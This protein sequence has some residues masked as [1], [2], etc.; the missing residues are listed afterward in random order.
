MARCPHSTTRRSSSVL[1]GLV[2]ADRRVR[3]S[4]IWLVSRVEKSRSG[5]V[6]AVVAKLSLSVMDRTQTLVT[7]PLSDLPPCVGL[8]EDV[9]CTLTLLWDCATVL[10]LYNCTTVLLCY[11]I[12]VLQYNCTTVLLYYC[13][14]VLLYYCATVQLCYCTTAITKPP[15]LQRSRLTGGGSPNPR[16]FVAGSGDPI[17][18]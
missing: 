10:Q 5:I 7:Q 8:G 11:C 14:T 2:P 15:L 4:C 3:E 17:Y 13:T 12:T 9:P 1:L 18:V 6:A 16:G